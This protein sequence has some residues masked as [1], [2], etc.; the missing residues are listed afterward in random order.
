[1]EFGP[2]HCLQCFPIKF[3][4]LPHSPIH[5]L[6]TE[7]T[8]FLSLV[9]EIRV[10]DIVFQCRFF[11][12]FELPFF[13]SLSSCSAPLSALVSNNDITFYISI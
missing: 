4:C 11:S 8:A 12:V 7:Y 13:T 9:G 6:P 1:M 2:Y 3:K 5:P 10:G